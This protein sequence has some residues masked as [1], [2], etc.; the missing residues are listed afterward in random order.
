M[1][2]KTFL[3]FAQLGIAIVL[4][5]FVL[6]QSRGTG[7]GEIFGGS[8]ETYRSKRGLEKILFLATIVTAALFL[9]ISIF[10]ALS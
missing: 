7:L 4:I 1:N 5:V 2:L 9:L 3:T 8:G 10:G 6:L